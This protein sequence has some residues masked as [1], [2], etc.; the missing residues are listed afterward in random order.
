MMSLRPGDVLGRYR[1]DRVVGQGGMGMVFA[2]TDLRLDRTVAV[3]V[4]TG[5]LGSQP[6]FRDRFH[7]EATA[8][9]RVDSPHVIQIHDHDEV[10]GVPFIVTQYVAGTDVSTLL[11]DRGP[12]PARTA[13]ELC[14]QVARGLSDVHGQGVLHR[15]VKP[16]NVLVRQAGT[17]QMH[18]YLCDFGIARADAAGGPAPTVAGAITGTWTY[19]APERL[20]GMPASP[21]SDLYALGCLLWTCLTGAPPYAGTEVQVALAHAQEPVPQLPGSTPF[22]LELNGVLARLLAKDPA[23]RYPDAATARAELLRLKHAAPP[24]TL[25]QATPPAVGGPTAVRHAVAQVRPSRRR[26]SPWPALAAIALALLI[27]VGGVTAWTLIRDDEPGRDRAREDRT[28]VVGDL[29]GDGDGDAAVVTVD[30]S[31]E[32][33]SFQR[34]P[35]TGKQF[36]SPVSDGAESGLPTLG[37]VD[38]DGVLDVLWFDGGNGVQP[39]LEARLVTGTG[40]I[41]DLAVDGGL[42]SSVLVS[43]ATLAD[44]TGDGRDDLVLSTS[45]A[46]DRVGLHVAASTG[47]GFGALEQWWRSSTDGVAPLDLVGSGD[48][49][50]DGDLELASVAN[51]FELDDEGGRYLE[52]RVVDVEDGEMSVGE[53]TRLDDGWLTAAGMVGDLDADSTSEVLL[54]NGDRYAIGVSAAEDGVLGAPEVV[55][56]DDIDQ[57]QWDGLVRRS[58]GP[59]RYDSTVSDVDGDGDTDVVHLDPGKGTNEIWVQ[60]AENG[61]LGEAVRWGEAPC[62]DFDCSVQYLF[63]R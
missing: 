29:D 36:G 6:E 12:M 57:E 2:A 20:A 52:L 25:E 42:D 49:D 60:P 45:E 13:L 58:G 53:A 34:I 30:R 19:L 44:V 63:V 27:L 7:H 22:V 4:I 11:H 15:D 31:G 16:G 62:P 8:M 38:G 54:V 5:P 37:D 24:D 10:D 50:G 47:G 41:R 9:S 17:P 46:D 39:M 21:A 32:L 14:A 35:S 26:R 33:T 1:L 3:K 43:G 59:G 48:L 56:R 51:V 55:S 18:A 28:R 23:H 61:E 40:E